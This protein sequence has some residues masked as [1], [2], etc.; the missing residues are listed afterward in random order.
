MRFEV[1]D[2]LSTRVARSSEVPVPVCQ[3]T[4]RHATE[5][6]AA[7]V[8]GSPTWYVLLDVIRRALE[9]LIWSFTLSDPFSDS[10]A[11]VLDC[12]VAIFGRFSESCCSFFADFH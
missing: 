3:T 6:L 10:V 1:L 2:A 11:L 4:L 9:S 5:V 12:S 7:A 8:G